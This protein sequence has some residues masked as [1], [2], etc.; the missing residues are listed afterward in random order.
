[1][2][3]IGGHQKPNKG[4]SDEWLT[5]PP[6]VNSLGVFDL[7]PCRPLVIPDGF[8]FARRGFNSDDDGLSQRWKGRVWMNP[9]YSHIKQW[10]PRLVEHG[11]GIAMVFARTD[12]LWWNEFVWPHADAVL[13]LKG[14]PRFHRLDGSRGNSN[15][16]GPVCL[17]AYGDHDSF[18]LEQSGL[19]GTLVTAWRTQA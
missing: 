1:M 7:D 19:V 13:F 11:D 14:R 2:K 18:R 8:K 16:G 15:S 12:V 4:Q 6:I 3:G 9:P 10:M 5:P 17:I